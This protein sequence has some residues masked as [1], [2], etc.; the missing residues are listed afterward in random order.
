MN[1]GPSGG[2]D[3]VAHQRQQRGDNDSRS[4]T[5]LAQQGG[6]HEIHGR[7]PPARPLD[8]K[9]PPL[10]RDEGFDGSPL[11]G[12]QPCWRLTIADEIRQHGI[13][14]SAQLCVHASMQPD[15]TGYGR[16]WLVEN[17]GFV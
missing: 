13:G 15:G 7:L 5:A 17:P 2:L 10:L 4:G 14:L 9:S 11:I 6:R 8:D 12:A 1:P 16:T 3:L